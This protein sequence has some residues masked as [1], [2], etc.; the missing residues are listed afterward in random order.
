M[1]DT[2]A[3]LTS[4]VCLLTAGDGSGVGG[5]SPELRT[6]GRG[7]GHLD[8]VLVIGSSQGNPDPMDCLTGK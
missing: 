4:S 6:F 8:R 3:L 7:A 1:V 5:H 2:K